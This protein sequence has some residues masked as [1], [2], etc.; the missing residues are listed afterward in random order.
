VP[1]QQPKEE[2][3]NVPREE[4]QQ[5]PKQVPKEECRQVPREECQQV[6]KQVPKQVT[7]FFFFLEQF[8][9]TRLQYQF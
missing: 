5:V 4:C 8:F 3:Y 2:C 9:I 1:K 6:P 7:A